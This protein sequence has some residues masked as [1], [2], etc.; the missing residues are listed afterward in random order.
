MLLGATT[1]LKCWGV[2]AVISTYAQEELWK[3]PTNN[4]MYLCCPDKPE[5]SVFS[6]SPSGYQI[7]QKSNN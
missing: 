1:N 2:V 6:K 3:T 5:S 4:Y 7:E